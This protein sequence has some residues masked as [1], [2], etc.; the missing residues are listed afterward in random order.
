MRLRPDRNI[1]FPRRKPFERNRFLLRM[2]N[3]RSSTS[4]LRCD[5]GGRNSR[6]AARS[7]YRL[8]HHLATA[9]YR[10][11][12]LLARSASRSAIRCENHASTSDAIHRFVP[13]P[14]LIGAGKRPCFISLDMC[15]RVNGIPRAAR[16]V[17]A[18]KRSSVEPRS[19][20]PAR[21]PRSSGI[22]LCPP[23]RGQFARKR[24]DRPCCDQ[25]H[26][27]AFK[28]RGIRM[29]YVARDRHPRC[30]EQDRQRN[31]RGR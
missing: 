13:A 31:V 21:L 16:S 29:Q 11:P 17:Y 18:R 5:G 30:D 20:E 24:L 25:V 4:G 14:S 6:R 7:S 12:L 26:A 9:T 3:S 23:M 22:A 19:R 2:R 8:R 28:L 1:L 27:F 15:C 10:S